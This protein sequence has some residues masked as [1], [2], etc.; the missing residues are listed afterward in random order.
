MDDDVRDELFSRQGGEPRPFR[1][2]DALVGVFPDA[3][4][5]SVPCYEQLM[6]L[7]GLLDAVSSLRG[8]TSSTSAALSWL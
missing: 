1:F 8:P 5:R 6:R 4:R 2:D 3:V 7:C